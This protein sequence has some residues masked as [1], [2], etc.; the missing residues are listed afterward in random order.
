M[1]GHKLKTAIQTLGHTQALKNGSVRPKTF[2]LDF[3]DVSPITQA[4]RRMVRGLEFDIAEMALTTYLCAKSHGK[5]FTAL[6]IF[7]VRAFHHGAILYNTQSSI[8]RPKDL[9][10]KRVGVNRGYTVTTGVW[11]RGILQHECGV[12][13]SKITWVLSGD[14]HVQEFQRTSNIISMEKGDTLE[15]MLA[16][17][18]LA[19]TIGITS[20]NPL[21]VPLIP[22]AVETGFQALV[23]RGHYPINHTL[24][25]RDDLLE[26]DPNVAV[27]IFNAFVKAKQIYI[28]QLRNGQVANPGK[29]DLTYQRVMDITKADPLPYGIGRNHEMIACLAQYAHEQG[30][31]S[32]PFE[33]EELFASASRKLA[34]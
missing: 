21:L 7:L 27:D 28:E 25:V 19:A 11:A 1:A 30:I 8:N 14:E 34:G 9:E 31:I 4:F 3:E 6:P 24:V 18:E 23:K 20:T 29:A 5:R 26:A 16:R 12:D 33:V 17:G 15:A 32:H 22:N 13:L 10:G 2:E